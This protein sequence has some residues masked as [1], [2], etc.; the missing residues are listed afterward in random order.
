MCQRESS[1]DGCVVCLCVGS[2]GLVD[3][4]APPRERLVLLVW[5]L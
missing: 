4:V 2:Q 3:L 1:V 5:P